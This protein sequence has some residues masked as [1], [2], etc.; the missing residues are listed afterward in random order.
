MWT[1]WG[2]CRE[3][4][5]EAL[6][7]GGEGLIDTDMRRRGVHRTGGLLAFYRLPLRSS[8]VLGASSCFR[9]EFVLCTAEPDGM[10]ADAIIL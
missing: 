1:V 10:M 6:G 7:V 9:R 5:D 8:R 4:E 3:E 2:V